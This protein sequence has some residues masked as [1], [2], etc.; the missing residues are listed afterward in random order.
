MKKKR[1]AISSNYK[2]QMIPR[3]LTRVLVPVV[4]EEKSFFGGNLE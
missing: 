3:V 4:E 2:L 1:A